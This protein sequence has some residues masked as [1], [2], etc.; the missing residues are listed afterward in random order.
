MPSDTAPH[1]DQPSFHIRRAEA[2][3]AEPILA[4]LHA[5]FEPYRTQY[6]P[7]AFADT[8]LT[9]SSLGTRWREMSLFVAVAG[10]RV[11]GTIG[12]RIDGSE[13]HLRGMA[14]LAE[15]QGSPVARELLCTAEDEVRSHGCSRVTLDTTEPLQRAI[16]FY[17]RNG[18]SPTGRVADF[19]G[20]PLY[21]YAKSL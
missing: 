3:D 6:S 4:C 2:G 19:F 17:V 8:V 10:S 14:V 20:M 1:R 9:A 11:V 7:E 5:A 15:W 21:E 13:G 16:H 18:Y 12:C